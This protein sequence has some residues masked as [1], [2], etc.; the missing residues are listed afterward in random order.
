MFN[1]FGL[2]NPQK[3]YQD[4][5]PKD[6]VLS[7]FELVDVREPVEFSSGHLPKATSLP[8]QQVQ[9]IEQIFAKD[10]KILVICQSGRRSVAACRKLHHLG[11]THL[12]NLKGGMIAWNQQRGTL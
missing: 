4:I 9:N 5:D 2:L 1:L 11:Y 10:K 12:Y 8:L 3:T 7:D 6:V